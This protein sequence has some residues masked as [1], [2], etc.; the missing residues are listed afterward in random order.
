MTDVFTQRGNLDPETQKENHVTR[1]P[2]KTAGDKPGTAPSGLRGN[3]PDDTLILDLQPPDFETS[4]SAVAR[5]S[6]QPEQSS[7]GDA[8]RES[9]TPP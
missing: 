5:V 3:H 1:H 7:T 6:R 4:S 8:P 2:E 9:E